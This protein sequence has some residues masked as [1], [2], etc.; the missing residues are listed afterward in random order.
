M[1]GLNRR[2]SQEEHALSGFAEVSG[3]YW[4]IFRLWHI[5]L[6]SFKLELHPFCQGSTREERWL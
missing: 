4:I 5:N 3:G 6:R 2:P 1:S